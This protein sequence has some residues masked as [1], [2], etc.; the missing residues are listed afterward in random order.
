[1]LFMVSSRPKAGATREQLIEHLTRRLDPFTW[2]LIRHTACYPRFYTRWEMNWASLRLVREPRNA[3]PTTGAQVRSPSA[4][5]HPSKN[6]WNR[7]KSRHLRAPY[8]CRKM[9]QSGHPGTA[10]DANGQSLRLLSREFKRRPH[11]RCTSDG[12]RVAL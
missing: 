12:Q 7:P 8:R 9:T 10:S 6:V 4:L 5:A 3:A 1:M 11:G 2:D